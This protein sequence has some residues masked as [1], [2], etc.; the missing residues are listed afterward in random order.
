MNPYHQ[1]AKR[2]KVNTST[3]RRTKA[4]FTL[5]ANDDSEEEEE[6]EDDGDWVSSANNS[7]ATTP[8]RQPSGDDGRPGEETV[9]S[10]QKRIEQEVKQAGSREAAPDDIAA[11]ARPGDYGRLQDMNAQRAPDVILANV[12]EQRQQ[13]PPASDAPRSRQPSDRAQPPPPTAAKP[14]PITTM[15]TLAPPSPHAQTRQQKAE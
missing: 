8:A 4:G 2:G 7:G 13:R 15:P 14:P 6:V 12:H 5:R 10:A 3:T 9:K 11:K 1:H